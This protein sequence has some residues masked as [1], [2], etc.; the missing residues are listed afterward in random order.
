MFN[1]KRPSLEELPTTAQLLKSTAIAAVSAVAILVAVVLPAEYNIDPTGFGRSL[2]LAEMG[3]IKQQLAEE[4]A[5][6]HSSLLDD[7][8][9]V[10]VSSA[11]VQEAQAEE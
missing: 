3:E 7:L 11:A 9:S 8:F 2:D 1:S 6:D 10:F 4:A 5:Q